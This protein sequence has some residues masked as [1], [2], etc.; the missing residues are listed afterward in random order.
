[1]RDKR[2][3]PKKEKPSELVEFTGLFWLREHATTDTDTRSKLL[4][5]LG[6]MAMAGCIARAMQHLKEPQGCRKFI[7]PKGKAATLRSVTAS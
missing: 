1:M 5:S 4:F 2:D 7:D 3:Y 6:G